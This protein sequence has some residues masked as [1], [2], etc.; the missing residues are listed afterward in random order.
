MNPG[1]RVT[2]FSTITWA[3]LPS[4]F[5]IHTLFS[6]LRPLAHLLHVGD[7]GPV[8]REDRLIEQREDR[9]IE[10][11]TWL[12]EEHAGTA[13]GVNEVQPGGLA[14]GFIPA[15]VCHSG[16]V[17]GDR[18]ASEVRPPHDLR[19][20]AI[21]VQD[22]DGELPRGPALQGS[23]D[24]QFCAVAGPSQRACRPGKSPAPWWRSPLMTRDRRPGSSRPVARVVRV[25]DPAGDRGEDAEPLVVAGGPICIVATDCEP[26]A[27]PRD[28]H[29][30]PEHRRG[31][32]PDLR[33]VP[34]P[35]VER[36]QHV[37]RRNDAVA[38]FTQELPGVIH[39]RHHPC[40]HG[41]PIALARRG[42]AP[43]PA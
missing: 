12:S 38:R 41:A 32:P 21:G 34:T 19:L 5:T 30:D 20:G 3:P 23:P 7:L 1:S 31:C 24:Q 43:S 13:I 14:L 17:G 26:P 28:R 33:V 37:A 25:E 39:R 18:C 16:T 6:Q 29:D 2:S 15:H 8:R 27:K 36:A 11:S 40:V 35:A 42:P 4:A 9:L 10:R 22:Q